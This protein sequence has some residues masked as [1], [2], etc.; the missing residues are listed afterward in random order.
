MEE[1]V[2][3]LEENYFLW[4]GTGS[5]NIF[6]IAHNGIGLY[7]RSIMKEENIERYKK[8]SKLTPDFK[9]AMEAAI[10]SCNKKT[11][12]R[13]YLVL[14]K[15]SRELFDSVVVGEIT[16]TPIINFD[17]TNGNE[18]VAIFI[19]DEQTQRKLDKTYLFTQ[20]WG[21]IKWKSILDLAAREVGIK[22]SITPTSHSTP[23]VLISD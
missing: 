1:A 6:N 21:F 17:E 2:S 15:V 10:A 22:I 23:W 20:I 11:D 8:Y 19:S 5:R 13:L 9:Q 12:E 3:S 16:K 4:Y 14:C 18:I 7:D